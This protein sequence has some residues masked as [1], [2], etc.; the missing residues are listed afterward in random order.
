MAG[1][2]VDLQAQ[3]VWTG[4]AA[5][6]RWRVTRLQLFGDLPTALP[7]AVARPLDRV[8]ARWGLRRDGGADS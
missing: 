7:G 6:R 4:L 8:L 2:R 5:F 3:V 1:H